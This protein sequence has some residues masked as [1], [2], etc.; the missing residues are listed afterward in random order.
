[1]ATLSDTIDTAALRSFPSINQP[2][3]E[4]FGAALSHPSIR[5][6]VCFSEPEREEGA[7][8]Y[9]DVLG[10]RNKLTIVVCDGIPYD[11]IA[12]IRTKGI[13]PIFLDSAIN[14]DLKSRFFRN[15]SVMGFVDHHYVRARDG[16]S[17][18]ELQTVGATEHGLQSL[19]LDHEA[20][21]RLL[22]KERSRQIKHVI[23]ED[24]FTYL[25][26]R[27]ALR[28]SHVSHIRMH[29]LGPAGTNIHQASE[30]YIARHGLTEKTELIVHDRGIEPPEYAE[31]AARE[32]EEG[33]LPLHMECAVY[34][35]MRELFCKR[36]HEAVFADHEYMPLD[37]MQLAANNHSPKNDEILKL[38]SHPSPVDL[39]HP[40][41]RSGTVQH[42]K[43]SSNADAA[44][45]VCDGVAD[46]CIT[47]ESAR[48]LYG[49]EKIHSFGSP[50][51][52]FTVGTPYS[53]EELRSRL[54]A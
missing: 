12:A 48:R 29:A 52:V 18:L 14:P 33:V 10:I 4:A 25:D 37:E 41:L 13:L 36:M 21:L 32:K 39:V 20:P 38:A 3:P 1:M 6:V 11:E 44:L 50:M 49:L 43:A 22:Q 34:Y 19:S 42:Q 5:E 7:Q 53:T 28:S 2:Q 16:L 8:L 51:M 45:Q 30:R 31:C 23:G 9:G 46:V 54:G 24:V 47:T 35:G 17:S 27:E 15:P 26:L 40:W